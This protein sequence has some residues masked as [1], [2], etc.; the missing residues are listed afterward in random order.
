MDQ[1]KKLYREDGCDF[2]FADNRLQGV[3]IDTNLFLNHWI[4]QPVT[5]VFRKNCF[6]VSLADKYSLF[7]DIHLIYH[8]LQN[9]KGYLFEFD[10]AVYREH[11]GG[12]HSKR[13]LKHQVDIGISLAKELYLKNKYNII[14][15]E[16]YIRTLNWGITTYGI[17]KYNI[18]KVLSFILYHLYYSKS[19]KKFIKNLS[20]LI[21][22]NKKIISKSK[23][24][25][26]KKEPVI[27]KP[28]ELKLSTICFDPPL[29]SVFM[30]TYNH[31]KYIKQAIESV[32]TQKTNFNYEI[33]IGEDC[34]IDSTKSII[35]DYE[36]NILI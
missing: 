34:S 1:E 9:G 6:D 21:L 24:K 31:D 14:L 4:T 11:I 27:I 22:S 35:E 30:V 33:V 19:I 28:N 29:V 2:L 32:L 18:T 16:N 5:M 25:I 13:P 12:L 23:Q 8:L 15:K 7:R 3:D 17:N 20:L 36:K 10:T 26:E